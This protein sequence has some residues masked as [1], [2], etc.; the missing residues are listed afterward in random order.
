MHYALP[1]IN[2]AR[3]LPIVTGCFNLY[4]LSQE[5]IAYTL[6]TCTQLKLMKVTENHCQPFTV[7][8]L[9]TRPYFFRFPVVLAMQEIDVIKVILLL[10]FDFGI[11]PFENLGKTRFLIIK[12]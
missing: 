10:L 12:V 4:Y 7:N 9:K 5:H 2:F 3:L 11:F 6:Y 1:L 8:F